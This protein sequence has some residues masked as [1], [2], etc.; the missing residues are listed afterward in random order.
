MHT[1][2]ANARE[3]LGKSPERHTL[4]GEITNAF[5]QDLCNVLAPGVEKRLAMEPPTT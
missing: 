5:A 2:W 4:E 3:K 1:F